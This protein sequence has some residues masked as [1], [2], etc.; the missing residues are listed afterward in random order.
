MDDGKK[1]GLW[2]AARVL[3]TIFLLAAVVFLVGPEKIVE[4]LLH[5]NLFF[6]PAIAVLMALI[7]L[8]NALAVFVLLGRIKKT[9]FSPFLK[10]YLS[11]WAIGYVL[12]G[13]IG[14]F[15]LAFFLKGE[16]PAG[17]TSAVVLIEK[18]ASF[19]VQF[20]FGILFFLKFGLDIFTVSL[21]S[22]IALGTVLFFAVSGPGRAILK[23]TIFRRNAELFAGFYKTLKSCL[24]E[25]KIRLAIAFAIT[26]CRVLV[27]GFS[28]S[29][30]VQ[31]FG[32]SA[33]FLDLTALNS[34]VSI[35]AF[36]PLTVSGLGLKE[37]SF[38]LFSSFLG[39]P[40]S[41]AAGAMVVSAVLNYSAVL[42]IFYFLLSGRIPEAFGKT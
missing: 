4:S 5:F 36:V 3:L 8:L 12:P 38:V 31:G 17:Q 23:K 1:S 41:A 18:L 33:G 22:A 16:I 13:K 26:A 6:L 40:Y 9:S 2:K 11:S 32:F 39:L 15:S 10:G 27:M 34:A 37:G 24:L 35:I 28:L 30:I 25:G 19:T 42:F 14:D 20:F 21:F 29:L 7:I